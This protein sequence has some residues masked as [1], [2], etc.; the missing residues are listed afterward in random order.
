MCEYS[1]GSY[2]LPATGGDNFKKCGR[3][4]VVPLTSSSWGRP[5]LLYYTAVTHTNPPVG[6]KADAQQATIVRVSSRTRTNALRP[7]SHVT[8]P[9]LPHPATVAWRRLR[10]VCCVVTPGQARRSCCTRC[11]PATWHRWRQSRGP[12]TAGAHPPCQRTAVAAP[13]PAGSKVHPNAATTS[14][15]PRRPPM[16]PVPPP[17]S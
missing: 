1:R 15:L 7:G 17:P 16:R 9:L 14:C 2:L 6:G 8:E 13:G 5:L 11:Q 10:R 3:Q 4:V 12:P